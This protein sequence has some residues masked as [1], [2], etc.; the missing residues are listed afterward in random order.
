VLAAGAA[1]NA[2]PRASRP[3]IAALRQRRRFG[4]DVQL[5]HAMIDDAQARRAIACA[6]RFGEPG[7]DDPADLFIDQRYAGY[8]AEDQETWRILFDRQHER[9]ASRASRAWR[10][11]A[12]RIRLVRDAIPRL[13]EVSARLAPLTGWRSRAVPGYLPARAFFACLARRE[14]PTTIVLRPRHALGYLP[15]PDIFHDVFGHV[16]LHAD[17][18]FA[19]FLETYGRIAL[20]ASDPGEL[21]RLTRLFWF[22][23][24]FGLIAERDGLRL[25]GSGLISSPN[26]ALHAL[27]SPD[28]ERRPFELEQ[29]CETPFEIDRFQPVLYVLESF[30]ELRDSMAAW[31]KSTGGPR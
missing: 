20:R 17:P 1:V 16:P 24:E 22:T 30:E 13:D 10:Q 27:E 8:S 3:E 18:V 5:S 9:L 31:E 28:V 12:E 26:E 4:E 15:E 19:E 11:G 25:Y 14:F 21:E 29:V 2:C 6:E 23:I 7:H